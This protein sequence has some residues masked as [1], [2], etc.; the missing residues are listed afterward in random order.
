MVH[1]QQGGPLVLGQALGQGGEPLLAGFAVGLPADHRIQRQEPPPAQVDRLVK[2]AQVAHLRRVVVVAGQ[3]EPGA[4]QRRQ[5]LLCQRVG[6]S[7]AVLADIAGHQH[8]VGTLRLY[9]PDHR[10]E[11]A[12]R[13]AGARAG[14]GVGL[15]VA[16]A[17]LDE[18]QHQGSSGRSMAWPW[19]RPWAS[20]S[21]RK[22]LSW[23]FSSGWNMRTLG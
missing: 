22:R 4:A 9:R 12:Q 11:L 6:G 21:P 3:P 15:Q 5:R 7:G 14:R 16:V 18:S 20:H 1:G 8:Q 10:L 23:S 17:D 13:E 2:L 19:A